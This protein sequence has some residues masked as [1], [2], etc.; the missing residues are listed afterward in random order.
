[1]TTMNPSLSHGVGHGRSL[2]QCQDLAP[3]KENGKDSSSCGALA[4]VIA[5]VVFII[6]AS[7]AAAFEVVFPVAAVVLGGAFLLIGTGCLL[8]GLFCAVVSAPPSGVVSYSTPSYT[9]YPSSSAYTAG[10]V[11]G[12]ALSGS[13]RNTHT[14]TTTSYAVPVPGRNPHPV[15]LSPFANSSAG[16]SFSGGSGFQSSWGSS[17]PVSTGGGFGFSGS[18][19]IGSTTRP[20]GNQSAWGSG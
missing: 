10:L 20:Y 2:Q 3:H 1:M 7:I 17:T 11:T 8:Y 12:A 4:A 15:N 6:L 14:H 13:G 9:Y 5:G 16:S 19:S 18:S